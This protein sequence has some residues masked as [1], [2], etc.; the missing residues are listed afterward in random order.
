MRLCLQLVSHQ[1]C[2]WGRGLMEGDKMQSSRVRLLRGVKGI[3]LQEHELFSVLYSVPPVAWSS[4]KRRSGWTNSFGSFLQGQDI[5][6]L[7]TS[8]FH[9]RDVLFLQTNENEQPQNS[10]IVVISTSGFNP[11]DFLWRDYVQSITQ[12]LPKNFWAITLANKRSWMSEVCWVL[13]CHVA[14]S[15]EVKNS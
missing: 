1:E 4:M 5:A 8:L 3:I 11:A 6:M 15:K 12:N 9:W 2:A 10:K 7:I 14:A 13:S